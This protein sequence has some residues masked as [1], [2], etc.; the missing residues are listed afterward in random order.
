MLPHLLFVALWVVAGYAFGQVPRAAE[1]YRIPLIAAAA[2]HLGPNAPIASLAGQLHQESGWRTDAKS[3]FANGLAQFTPETAASLARQVPSL[4][5]PRPWEASW[6]LEAF[7]W[8]MADELRRFKPGRSTT[9]A[10][11]MAASSYNGGP[12][13]LAREIA[14]CRAD[15]GCDPARWFGHV[16][17]KNARAGW[18]W[19]ENRDYIVRILVRGEVYRQA[20][21]GGTWLTVP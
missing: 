3:R 20:G 19:T 8:L 5:P 14:Q 10:G 18:A 1:Q 15:P 11:L 7:A 16:E 6:S 2:K 13:M 4:R 9:S 17:G 12:T 21:W